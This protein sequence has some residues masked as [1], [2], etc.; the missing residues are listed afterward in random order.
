M[1]LIANYEDGIGMEAALL[2]VLATK[3][4]AEADAV[5]LE[6]FRVLGLTPTNPPEDL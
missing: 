1:L 4:K 2:R 3:P 6:I 5:R